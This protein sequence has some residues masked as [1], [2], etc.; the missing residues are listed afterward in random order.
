MQECTILLAERYEKAGEKD[1]AAK[2]FAEFFVGLDGRADMD[3]SSMTSIKSRM[4]RGLSIRS[5][6]NISVAY[7]R[8]TTQKTNL[9]ASKKFKQDPN[10]IQRVAVTLR[11]KQEFSMAE[12][13]MLQAIRVQKQILGTEANLD[14]AYMY[15]ELAVTYESGEKFDRAIN[16]IKRQIN[17]FKELQQ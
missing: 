13:L 5:R 14:I 1:V 10:Q 8:K 15:S 2:L 7:S 11:Q 12:R 4:S 6:T 9:G 16:C 3:P 17:I